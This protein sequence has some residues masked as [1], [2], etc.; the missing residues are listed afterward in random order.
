[1]ERI[2][3]IDEQ[4]HWPFDRDLVVVRVEPGVGVPLPLPA[5]LPATPVPVAPM[6]PEAAVPLFALALPEAA[7]PLFAPVPPRAL[8]SLE[9]EAPQAKLGRAPAIASTTAAN[10]NVAKGDAIRSEGDGRPA[11]WAKKEVPRFAAGVSP[12]TLDRRKV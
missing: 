12:E 8:P 1:M 9:T 5:A 11:V 10:F 3:E 6:S 2:H 7:V 4:G